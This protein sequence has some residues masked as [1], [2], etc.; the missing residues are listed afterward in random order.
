MSLA[1]AALSGVAALSLATPALA[2]SAQAL[3]TQG[4]AVSAGAKAGQLE[5]RG[6]SRDQK[7]KRVWALTKGSDGSAQA[8]MNGYAAWRNGK[9]PYGFDWKSD[10]CSGAADYPLGFNFKAG[11]MRHDFGYRNF[12]KLHAFSEAN[13]LHV[14]KAFLWELTATCNEQWGK[15]ERERKACRKIAKKYYQA[16]R[17]FGRL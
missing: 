17:D 16:V 14:D 5:T 8:Y 3:R 12:K 6:Y 9:N 7:I 2:D 15:P 13:R 10:G 4:P 1:G 11:C